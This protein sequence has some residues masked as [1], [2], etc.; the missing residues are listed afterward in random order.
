MK[1]IGIIP[2]RYASS[3]FPGK[4]LTNILGKSMIQRVYEQ[5]KKAQSLSEIIIATDDERILNHVVKF[6]GKAIMTSR[7]HKSGTE[8]CNEAVQQLKTKYDIVINIQGDEPFI[9]PQQI[10]QITSILNSSKA[11]IAT[12][13]KKIH[14]LSILSDLNNPKA[15]IN[16]NNV[17]VNFCRLINNITPETSYYKHIGIYGY[18]TKT[19]NEICV[20][21]QSINEKKE[22]LEQLRWLD[23]KYLIKVGITPYESISIDSPEDIEKIKA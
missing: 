7:K 1:V 4:P 23:N 13:A 10:D 3:R 17:A 21:P 22:Q 20:L 18:H 19:L 8:R 2:A 11:T 14:D 15:I 6:G 16:E 9:H 12:L 5:C